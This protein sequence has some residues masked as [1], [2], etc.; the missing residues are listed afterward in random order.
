MT[1]LRP[2]QS[3]I[4]IPGATRDFS[5]IQNVWPNPLINGYQTS[6]PGVKWQGNEVEHPPAPSTEVKNEWSYTSGCPV[7]LHDV[8][9]YSFFCIALWLHKTEGQ[10]DIWREAEIGWPNIVRTNR[11]PTTALALYTRSTY[12][13]HFYRELIFCKS[14]IHVFEP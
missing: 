13:A 2:G 10:T 14:L 7:H 4:Q 5:P 9:R 12:Y 6:F 11:Y 1:T 3:R 8:I